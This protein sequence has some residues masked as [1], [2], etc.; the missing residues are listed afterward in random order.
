MAGRFRTRIAGTGSYLPEKVLTNYDLEKMVETN[1]DWI[2][3]RTGIHRRHIAGP[4]EATSDLAYHAALRALADAKMKPEDLDAIFFCTVTPDQ[5]M[6][7][8]ACYLQ[9]K[10]KCRNIMAVDL[11]AACSGFLYGLTV[12][13]QMIRTGFYKNVLVVGAECISRYLNYKDRETCIL[14]GDAAGA[15]VVTQTSEDDPNVIMTSHLHAEGTLA[16]LLTMEV[17][18]ARR[19]FNQQE[20]DQS[21]HFMKMKGREIFK[22]AVRTMALTCKEAFAANNITLHD[23]DWLIPHQANLRIMEA[24]ADQFDFPKNKVIQF[25]HETGNTSAASIP[26]AFQNSFDEGKIKRGQLILLTAFGAGLTS[27]SLL[28]RF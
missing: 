9:A 4:G 18:G 5:L 10:L 12:A 25:V 2:V 15:W 19:P 22:N 7:A 13:D 1:H 14:F 26:T 24:V 3:E 8:S 28:L 6:P 11:N 16:D 27:G 20:L 21:N 17:G 23:I